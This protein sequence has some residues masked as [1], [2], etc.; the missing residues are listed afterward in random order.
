MKK[1]IF[2]LYAMLMAS[3]LLWACEVCK[4]KQPKVLQ[5]IT[6]GAGPDGNIDYMI[7]WS[8]VVIVSITL[9]LSIKYLVK[10]KENAPEHIK[11]IIVE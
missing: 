6:H 10:P 4:E 9:F 5:G 7:I 2:F 1:I 3:P 11:N 8:A